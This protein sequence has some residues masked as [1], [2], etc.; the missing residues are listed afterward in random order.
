VRKVSAIFH[1]IDANNIF[2]LFD[3]SVFFPMSFNALLH[4]SC[5]YR[6]SGEK[7]L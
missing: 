6:F 7:A 3:I 2:Q 4:F 5:F 1:R